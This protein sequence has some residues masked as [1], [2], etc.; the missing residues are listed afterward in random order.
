MCLAID[1]PA[2]MRNEKHS[3]FSVPSLFSLVA[4]GYRVAAGEGAINHKQNELGGTSS[5]LLQVGQMSSVYLLLQ[6]LTGVATVLRLFAK[7]Q[8]WRGGGADHY[9]A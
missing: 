2:G 1:I 5:T 8:T 6:L 3:Y 7:G 4:P 9:I